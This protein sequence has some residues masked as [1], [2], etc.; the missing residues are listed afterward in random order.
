MTSGEFGSVAF[1]LMLV[2][3]TANLVGHLFLLMRQ[4]RIV[5]EILASVPIGV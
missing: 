1:A 5:G 3:G 4:P 2:I